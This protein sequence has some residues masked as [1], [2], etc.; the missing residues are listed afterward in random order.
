MNVLPFPAPEE[1]ENTEVV[2]RIAGQAF[3][4]VL[5]A[6]IEEITGKTA[7]VIE[8]PENFDRLDQP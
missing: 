3:R 1:P 2:V 6:R 5:S 4:I 8:F 7:E